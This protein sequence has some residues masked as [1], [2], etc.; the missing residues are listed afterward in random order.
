[1]D[2]ED[3]LTTIDS[4]QSEQNRIE[5]GTELA[6]RKDGLG[7]VW[8]CSGVSM[9]CNPKSWEKHVMSTIHCGYLLS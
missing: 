3:G 4:S 5:D 9:T 1:M 2:A 8:G 6:Q 7:I